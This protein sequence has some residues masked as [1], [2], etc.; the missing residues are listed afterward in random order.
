M[1]AAG[2]GIQALCHFLGLTRSALDEHLVRLGLATPHDR[3]LRQSG[4]HPWSVL[5]TVRLIAW[6][7]AGVHH[8]G[9]GL[10]LGRSANAVRA[11]VRRLK[12]IVAEDFSA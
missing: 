1:V 6:R 7:I 3:P 2:Q 11:K 10:R 5:D 4:R 12:R 9:I 8:E